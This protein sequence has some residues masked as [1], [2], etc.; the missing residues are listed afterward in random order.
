MKPKNV[1]I[2]SSWS[3]ILLLSNLTS[4][5]ELAQNLNIEVLAE[6]IETS[7]HVNFLRKLNCRYGQGYYYSK[8]LPAKELENFLSYYLPNNVGWI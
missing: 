3:W 6:G 1:I 2:S 7:E 5:V 4:C 8:P